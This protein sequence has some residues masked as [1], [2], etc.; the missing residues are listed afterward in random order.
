MRLAWDQVPHWGKRRKK[1]GVGEKKKSANEV[2]REVVWRGERVAAALSLPSLRLGSL[3]SPIFFLFDLVPFPPLP[4]L[5][6]GYNEA[7]VVR[8]LR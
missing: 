4:S 3:R 7:G 5:V 1:I 2:S 6:P 8:G